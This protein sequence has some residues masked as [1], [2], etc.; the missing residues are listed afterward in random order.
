MTLDDF[1]RPP[2]PP[3][4][5]GNFSVEITL[6]SGDVQCVVELDSG[7]RWAV[8]ELRRQLE[9]QALVGMEE[10]DESDLVDFSAIGVSGNFSLEVYPKNWRGRPHHCVL[11]GDAVR[12]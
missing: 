1:L 11:V 9:E 8:W 2:P 7:R 3:V 12:D 4:V 6:L 5:P 10:L